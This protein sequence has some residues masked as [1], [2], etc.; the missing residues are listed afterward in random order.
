MRLLIE[1]LQ[2]GDKQ[3]PALCL[4]RRSCTTTGKTV[5]NRSFGGLRVCMRRRDRGHTGY[6]AVLRKNEHPVS[7]TEYTDAML[8]APPPP[9]TQKPLQL[10]CAH[11]HFL[12]PMPP[13]SK[14]VW[15][16]W[17]PTWTQHMSLAA[18]AQYELAVRACSSTGIRS[19]PCCKRTSS[20]L[21]SAPV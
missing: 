9:Y 18:C 13:N 19:Q 1:L 15:Q 5:H 16:R 20:S 8:N 11:R 2:T 4:H 10:T 21:A 14:A 3:R 7:V 6:A 17:I 12:P